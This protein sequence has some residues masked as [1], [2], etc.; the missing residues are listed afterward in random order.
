[1]EPYNDVLVDYNFIDTFNGYVGAFGIFNESMNYAVNI[2]N[3]ATIHI[4][5]YSFD[6]KIFKE[7]LLTRIQYEKEKHWYDIIVQNSFIIVVFII[8]YFV[9]RLSGNLTEKIASR[10]EK[11]KKKVK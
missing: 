3:I 4:S 9:F 8:S 5:L 10:D 1:M 2:I 11:Q 7:I 6:K